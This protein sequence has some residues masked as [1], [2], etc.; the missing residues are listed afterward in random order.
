MRWKAL[1]ALGEANSTRPSAS[2]TTTPSPTRGASS[3]PTSSS[4]NGNADSP[5]TSARPH[6][7]VP[8]TRGLLGAHVL[9]GERKCGLRHHLGQPFEHI[10]VSPLEHADRVAAGTG[11][12]PE[13]HGD[14]PALTAHR[15]V[16]HRHLLA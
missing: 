14:H 7:P 6:P 10:E 4:G 11:A 2:T 9:V 15:D 12:H 3:V 5:T 13:Q 1:M 8:D 16:L